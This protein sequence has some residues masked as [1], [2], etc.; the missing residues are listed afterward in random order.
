M[1]GVLVAILVYLILL[2]YADI[3]YTKKMKKYE[4]EYEKE[5]KATTFYLI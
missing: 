3:R 4:E 2:E 1:S 5:K